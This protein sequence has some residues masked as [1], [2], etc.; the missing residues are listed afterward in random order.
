MEESSRNMYKGPTDKA[1]VGRN[2]G[3]GPGGGEG[4]EMET[5]VLEQQ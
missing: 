5:T 3:G 4:G 1:K 2:D